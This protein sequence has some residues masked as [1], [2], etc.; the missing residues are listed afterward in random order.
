MAL[1]VI[2]LPNVNFKMK[3]TTNMDAITDFEFD[4]VLRQ[5]LGIYWLFIHLYVQNIISI[6]WI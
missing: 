3:L 1:V 6:V 2:S 5:I 4:T